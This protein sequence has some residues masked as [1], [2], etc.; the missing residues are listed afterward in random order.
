MTAKVLKFERRTVA[1]SAPLPDGYALWLLYGLLF[2][3][4]GALFF[5]TALA[6]KTSGS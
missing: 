3:G 4:L 6:S 2:C 1:I 5:A